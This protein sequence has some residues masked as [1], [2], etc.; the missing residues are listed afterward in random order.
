MTLNIFLITFSNGFPFFSYIPSMKNGTRIRIMINVAALFP[1]FPRRS[2]NTGIPIPPPMPKQISCRFVKLKRTF[3]LIFEKSFGTGTYAIFHS[4][5]LAWKMDL[6]RLPVLN[7]VKQRRIRYPMQV[8]AAW[9]MS[10]STA[11]FDTNTA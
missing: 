4:F 11:I 8:Q 10:S 1:I 3:V 9:I 6:L 7:M 2:K 5:Q